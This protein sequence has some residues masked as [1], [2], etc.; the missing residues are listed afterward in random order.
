MIVKSNINKKINVPTHILSICN[1]Y[2]KVHWLFGKNLTAVR[3]PFGTF[4]IMDLSDNI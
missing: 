1:D 2:L 4:Q 3:V